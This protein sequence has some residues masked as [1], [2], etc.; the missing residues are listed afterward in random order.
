MRAFRTG[1][2]LRDVFT[3]AYGSRPARKAGME[4]LSTFESLLRRSQGVDLARQ[5]LP[6]WLGGYGADHMANFTQLRGQRPDLRNSSLRVGDYPILDD[7]WPLKEGPLPDLARRG[8]QAAGALAADT[9][10]QG[11]LNVYWFLNA[12]EA[13]AMAAGQQGLYGALR[14]IPDAPAGNPLRPS[15]LKVAA[16]YPL[17]L[18]ASAASGGLFRQPGYAAVLPSSEDRRESEDPVYERFLRAI[19]RSGRLLPYEQFKEERPDVSKFEYDRYKAYLHGN[20]GAIVRATGDGIHGPEVNI[21]GKSL[22][23]LTGVAPLIGGVIGG[24]IGVRMAGNRLAGTEGRLGA[25]LRRIPGVDRVSQKLPNWMQ[26]PAP[27]AVNQFKRQATQQYEV[28]RIKGEVA[29][30][31]ALGRDSTAFG[32]QFYDAQRAASAQNRLVDNTLLGGAIAG[33]ATGLTVTAA[34]ANLLE[35]MR[36]AGAAEESRRRRDEWLAGREAQQAQPT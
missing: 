36:R 8:A 2:G 23:L 6:R 28:N 13:A 10:T 21:L 31:D 9:T 18:G 24:R 5:Y 22:P 29:R 30:A 15:M 7:Q 32:Q 35:Q 16:T 25:A 27:G 34:A 4:D 3:E 33:T 1:L 17:I 26:G 20:R 12:V 11:A 14:K 19:G